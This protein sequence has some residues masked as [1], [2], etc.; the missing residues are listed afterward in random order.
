MLS[1]K[2]SSEKSPPAS[3]PQQSQSGGL[4]SPLKHMTP[5]V[6]DEFLK[7]MLSV[8][9]R[10]AGLEGLLLYEKVIEH[11]SL[12]GTAKLNFF[13]TGGRKL[14]FRHPI[15]VNRGNAQTI[16][17]YKKGLVKYG[18]QPHC[19]GKAIAVPRP[20]SSGGAS[21]AGAS[22]WLVGHA[23]LTEALYCAAEE[24]KETQKI[25]GSANPQLVASIRQGLPDPLVL[26]PRTPRDVLTWVKETHNEFH[27]GASQTILE[28]CEK[29]I[30][31]QTAWHA[32]LRRLQK[33]ARDFPS[34]GPETYAKCMEAT[35]FS[36][37]TLLPF[38]MFSN[39]IR[40]L[41]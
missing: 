33:Q 4:A 16:T 9:Q 19:R 1:D 35:Y 2:V 25:K 10:Y 24:D 12:P 27:K 29:A 3:D 26:S 36:H 32:E 13:D 28:H 6:G 14:L 40:N 39:L 5:V 8:R 17:T 34:A 22:F 31:G 11:W 21:G 23:T 38:C 18:L 37:I 20:L 41:C 15:N 30:D 7:D